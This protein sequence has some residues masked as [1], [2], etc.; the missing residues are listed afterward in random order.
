ML[1]KHQKLAQE[2]IREE[3]VIELVL[4]KQQCLEIIS[5]LSTKGALISPLE[6]VVVL[7]FMTSKVQHRSAL[8]K[9]I[10]IPRVTTV[11]HVEAAPITEY[12]RTLQD[13]EELERLAKWLDFLDN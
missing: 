11:N 1:N 12:T 10:F 9:D 4:T 7:H 13:Q 6:Q 8:L 2:F 5:L 3:G